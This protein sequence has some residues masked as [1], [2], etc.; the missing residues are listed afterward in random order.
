MIDMPPQPDHVYDVV[1]WVHVIERELEKTSIPKGKID[2]SSMLSFFDVESKGQPDAYRGFTQYR[3]IVQIGR[4]AT[5]EALSRCEKHD[6]SSHLKEPWEGNTRR[7]RSVPFHNNVELSLLAFFLIVYEYRSMHRY[8][9]DLIAI[10]WKS[11]PGVLKK[12]LAVQGTHK[13]NW[14]ESVRIAPNSFEYLRRFRKKRAQYQRYIDQI[15]DRYKVC[16][17]SLVDPGAFTIYSPFTPVEVEQKNQNM[18]FMF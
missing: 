7:I 18:S 16:S 14:L 5:I 11:G 3:G 8:S 12:Y 9:P 6:W 2:M 15:N 1:R 4:P 10:L 17:A 13:K